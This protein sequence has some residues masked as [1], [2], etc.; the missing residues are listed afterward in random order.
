M[1]CLNLCN[2]T[3]MA[4][5][6]PLALLSALYRLQIISRLLCAWPITG[7]SPE[8]VVEDPTV[9]YRQQALAKVLKLPAT[10]DFTVPDCV[11]LAT[12]AAKSG[13]VQAF[14]ELCRG[15]PQL[16][17]AREELP[18]SVLLRMYQ[19]AI[20]EGGCLMRNI[21]CFLGCRSGSHLMLFLHLSVSRLSVSFLCLPG[22]LS[23]H[24]PA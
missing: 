7:R 1:F 14:T 22:M 24:A 4:A 10:D 9:S 11:V 3:L 17:L 5:V 12:T 13:N 15:L 18:A 2:A 21:A 6:V 8:S 19:L 23:A 20:D 16:R